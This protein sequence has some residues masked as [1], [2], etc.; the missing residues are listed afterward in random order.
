V[1]EERVPREANGAEPVGGERNHGGRGGDRLPLIYLC[2]RAVLRIYFGGICR[3]RV[4][5]LV[6]PPGPF[7]ISM[8]HRSA[9]DMFL[10]VAILPRRLKF[11]AKRELLAY[12][13]LGGILRRWCVP[14]NRGAYDRRAL[15]ACVQALRSG[16]VLSVFPEGTRRAGLSA[17]H[18]GAVL[19][20]AHAGVPVV[21]G[22]IVGSYR[23]FGQITVRFG[24]PM[25]FP[26]VLSREE[27]LRGTE[28]LMDTIRGLVGGAPLRA[29][30]PPGVGP[31]AEG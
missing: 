15:S 28:E 11:L 23:P 8:N 9:L 27:R 22:A 6:L 1:S 31:G 7:V 21:P 20:A 25:V 14:V 4:E 2:S 30:P 18:G 26:R 29:G 3:I 17:G 12:P 16:F 13:L 10:Y 5:N 24:Q 19:M